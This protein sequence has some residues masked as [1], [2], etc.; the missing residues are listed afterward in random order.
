M[1]DIQNLK[2]GLVLAGGGGKGAYE[3]GVI[4]ALW[5]LGLVKNI[6]AVSGSSIGTVNT[7]LFCMEDRKL[8]DNSW[9][10]LNYAQI[11]TLNEAL[12]FSNI[13]MLFKSWLAN[14]KDIKLDI[15]RR[16]HN[17]SYF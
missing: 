8:I 17:R 3:A 10:S 7:L 9:R 12:N 14:R 11:I 6:T 5:D 15:E 13:S 16:I 2:M 1:R 4:A